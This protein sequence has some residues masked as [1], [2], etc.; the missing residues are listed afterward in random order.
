MLELDLT[1]S[2]ALAA[3]R[4]AAASFRPT[5]LAF[6]ATFRARETDLGIHPEDGVFEINLKLVLQIR[7]TPRTTP[8]SPSEKVSEAEKVA[9]NVGKIAEIG[10]IEAARSRAAKPL[11]PEAIIAASLVPIAQDA[12]GLRRPLELVLG[13]GIPRVAVRVILHRQLAVGALNLLIP[14]VAWDAELFVVVLLFHR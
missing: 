1:A 7:A 10:R 6:P 5:A 2:P 9:E 11:V 12:V 4:R 3:N 13:L 14:R 8:S